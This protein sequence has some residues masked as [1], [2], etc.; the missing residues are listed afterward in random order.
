MKNILIG[1]LYAMLWASASVATKFG[2]NSADPLILAN[3]RFFIA[4]PL[5]LAFAYAAGSR[6]GY[7]LPAKK[8]WLRL[9]V[10]GFLNTTLYLGLYVISMK[11]TA[12]GIG[13]LATSLG[14]LFITLLSVRMLK[15]KP[16]L[17][18][19]AGLALG[20]GGVSIAT[21]PLLGIG[22]TTVGGVCL[23]ITSMFVVSLASVY[24]ARVPWQLPNLLINGWQVMLGG[25]FLLPL[26]L[27]FG[28]FSAFRADANFWFS[29][30]WLSIAVSIFGLICWF[31]LLSRDT[32]KA[33]LWQFLC[34]IF[35]FFFAWWLMN[36]PITGGTWIGTTLVIA[37]LLLARRK[38][39]S[40][41]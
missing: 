37:G 10:F 32:V 36:E 26:T 2:L 23:L 9:A 20:I 41:R 24:Y 30:L 16:T 4:G 21:Y 6:P 1:L 40:P 35:G 22:Q 14:P 15:R 33:S 25:I 18:E 5:L 17:A 12:A 38:N 39:D 27:A 19:I 13:S 3:T 29:V 34:P 31:Y 7:R 11:Y 8:E 28:D